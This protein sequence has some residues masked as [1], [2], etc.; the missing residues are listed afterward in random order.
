MQGDKDIKEL[1]MRNKEQGK[2]SVTFIAEIT[3]QDDMLCR[4]KRRKESLLALKFGT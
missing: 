1:T 3:D 2:K 4:V